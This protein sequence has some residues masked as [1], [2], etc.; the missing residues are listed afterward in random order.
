VKEEKVAGKM[1]SIGGC[2]KLLCPGS[3]DT[4]FRLCDFHGACGC[5]L[6]FPFARTTY[7]IILSQ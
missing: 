5:M 7:I 4:K 3:M 2:G 1:A 6:L